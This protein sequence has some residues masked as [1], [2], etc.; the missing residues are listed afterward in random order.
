MRMPTLFRKGRSRR[1]PAMPPDI[2]AAA[3]GV[4]EAVAPYT[5]T[6]PER[7]LA[8]RDAV[9]HV[10]RHAIEGDIVECGVW[11][12]GSMMAAALTL[13]GLGEHRRL[14]LFDTFE[15][16][17]PPGA[18]DRDIG[19]AAA[20]DL[21]A[22]EDRETGSTW[23]FGPLADVQHNLFSTGYP[24]DLIQFVRGRVEETIP[25]HAPEQIAVLRLDT[26]WYESTRHE[27]VHLFPRLAVGGVLIIDDYGHWKGARKAVDEYIAA[28]G[29]RLLLSRIDYTGRMAVKIDR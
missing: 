27:L 5:M 26:D 4:I 21:L 12:G 29:A 23:A 16:M 18:E 17:P 28:T 6:S 13:A 25:C 2:D 22:E 10:C 15:G 7:I 9:Q 14:H 11:R 24:R 1:G 8:L 20:E 3:R 19:G